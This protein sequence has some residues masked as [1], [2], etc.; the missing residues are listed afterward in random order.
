MQVWVNTT[1]GGE[2]DRYDYDLVH[3]DDTTVLAYANNGSW[4]NPGDVCGSLVDDGD[5]VKIKIDGQKIKID[6]DTLERLFILLSH[7]NVSKF[8]FIETKIV[9]EI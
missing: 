6:Y 9:K 2:V 1:R 7:H 8:Q 3:Y 5:G 4:S